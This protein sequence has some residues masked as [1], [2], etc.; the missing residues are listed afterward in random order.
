MSYS[1]TCLFCA[2]Y[3][4]ERGYTS[5]DY[6]D[7]VAH[8]GELKVDYNLVRKEPSTFFTELAEKLRELWPPGEKEGKY[9]WR[10]SVPNLRKRLIEL[11]VSRFNGKSYTIEQCLT[12]ARKY[13]SNFQDDTR[14]MKVLKYF[15]L[16]Q[17]DIVDQNGKATHYDESILADMLESGE[18]L[19]PVEET[20]DYDNLSAEEGVLI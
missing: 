10:D 13:L 8:L 4:S 20:I 18:Y 15:I 2:R 7:M 6:E 16:K 11:W 5:K 1:D 14:Y 12:V 19:E 17:K 3:L 9:P